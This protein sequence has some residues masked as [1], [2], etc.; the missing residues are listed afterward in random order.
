MD[1]ILIVEDNPI[2][3]MVLHEMLSDYEFELSWAKDGAEF[4]ELMEGDRDYSLILMDLMLPD[5]DGIELT[6]F[7]INNKITIPIVF[8][9]AYTERCEEVYDLGVEYFLTKPIYKELFFSVI[10]KYVMV[11]RKELAN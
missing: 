6:K 4:F 2:N 11:K 10:A 9:S 1:K 8:I 5:T 3:Y 7:C